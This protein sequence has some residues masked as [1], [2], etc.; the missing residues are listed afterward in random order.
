MEEH[1][2]EVWGRPL[3]TVSPT[4]CTHTCTHTTTVRLWPGFLGDDLILAQTA[5][6]SL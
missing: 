4:P 2:D 1:T 3:P 5:E 6:L